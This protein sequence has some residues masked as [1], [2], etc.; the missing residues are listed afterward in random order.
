MGPAHSLEEQE[1]EDTEKESSE[2]GEECRHEEGAY[3]PTT[4]RPA[5]E[6]REEP[7]ETCP[8]CGRLLVKL[9][10]VKAGSEFVG[11]AGWLD[12]DKSCHYMKQGQEAICV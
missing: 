8:H 3:Q 1:A 5:T 11:C 10:S 4:S 9:F 12:K 2:K 7:R 6:R